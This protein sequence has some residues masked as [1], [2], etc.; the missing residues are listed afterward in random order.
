MCTQELTE[1]GGC[2]CW[3]GKERRGTSRRTLRFLVLMS[4]GTVKPLTETGH[5]VAREKSHVSRGDL[6]DLGCL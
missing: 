4:A 6:L 5:V 2:L 1:H 3:C